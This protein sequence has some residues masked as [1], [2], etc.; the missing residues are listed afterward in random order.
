MSDKNPVYLSSQYRESLGK[1]LDLSDAQKKRLNKKLK[2]EL[3]NWIDNA[4][5]LHRNLV[6]WNDLLEGIVPETDWP[7]QGASNV[8]VPIIGIY[9]KVYHSIERRS[10]LGSEN[11]WTIET[12]EETL[13]ELIPEVEEAINYKSRNEWNISDALSDVFWTTNRDGLGILEIEYV[14]EIEE[15]VKDF[16]LISTPEQF[17]EE[18]PTPEESQ[19]AP[20]QWMMLQQAVVSQA[21]LE[22]P[23]EIPIVY[24]KVLYRGPYAEVIDLAD[25]VVLP[26]TA[27]DIS[28]RH[29][30]GYGKRFYMRKALVK[31]K[32]KSGEWDSESVKELLEECKNSSE[33]SEY[34]KAK[35]DI[36]GLSRSKDNDEL[37]FFKLCY[38][39]K[40]EKEGKDVKLMVIYNLEYEKLV[41]YVEFPLRIDNYALFRI[42][43]RPNR[44]VGSCIPKELE[45]LNEEIDAL[46]NQRINSRKIAEV[47]SFKGKKSA[48]TD[49]DPEAEA[50]LWRPGVI[51][52]LDDPDSF[53]QFKVQPV[54]LNSSM[55]EEKNDIQISSLHVGVEPFL[56][57]GNPASQN[58]DAP[59]NK[60]AMLIQ[61]SNLRMDDPISE[62]RDGVEAVGNIIL[63]LEYQFGDN[64]I[65]YVSSDLNGVQQTKTVP[66]RIL[67]KGLN[68]RMHG[69]T[70]ALNPEAE[71]SKWMQMTMALMQFPMIQS[72]PESQHEL[73]SQ[74]L[75]SGRVPGRKKILPSLQEMQMQQI[76]MM[77]QAIAQAEVEKDNMKS[78][79]EVQEGKNKNAETRNQIDAQ[80][81]K[82]KAAKQMMEAV[83]AGKN[84]NAGK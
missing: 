44:L 53:D 78:Q 66:K 5:G 13:R 71:F 70:V 82:I 62:L 20:E 51:F 3:E 61:Q 17:M 83:N 75:R 64:L 7:F 8:H 74:T 47:P 80:G 18:F 69:V 6:R 60:T 19:M 27:I 11:I 37:E 33:I 36:E 72:R 25:F 58:P 23:L 1:L 12:S 45:D 4:S 56:F 40:L 52:W 63:A 65:T 30:R 21:T 57:S 79:N 32:G 9:C 38:H 35:E 2:K 16:V 22:D 42:E 49:F 55:L 50:N 48:K 59:G 81:L 77:S 26:A 39:C 34:K 41:F 43:K 10:I 24:D 46:H 54:D 84:G 14:E 29:A 76:Q 67:R 15:D 73:L 31:Q 28:Y 68:M